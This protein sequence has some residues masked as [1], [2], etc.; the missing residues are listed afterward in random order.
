M[1]LM[2]RACAFRGSAFG[3]LTTRTSEAAGRGE[4]CIVIH[5]TIPRFSSRQSHLDKIAARSDTRFS[6][7][8]SGSS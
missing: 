6:V 7:T 4:R 3:N 2:Q 8:T 1:E 5:S